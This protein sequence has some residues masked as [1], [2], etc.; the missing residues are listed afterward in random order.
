MVLVCS[1][2]FELFDVRLLVSLSMIL[3]LFQQLGVLTPLVTLFHKARIE[4]TVGEWMHLV[5]IP[6]IISDHN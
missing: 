3:P 5:Q 1:C 2:I 6:L 4:R